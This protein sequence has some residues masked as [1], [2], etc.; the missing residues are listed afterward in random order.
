MRPATRIDAVLFGDAHAATINAACEAK[1]HRFAA[2]VTTAAENYVGASLSIGDDGAPVLRPG[3]AA[4]DIRSH[5]VAKRAAK[6]SAGLNRAFAMGLPMYTTLGLSGHL[7]MRCLTEADHTSPARITAQAGAHFA[8][9]LAMY[10]LLAQRVCL[11]TAIFAPTRFDT[12]TRDAWMIFD[13]VA[14]AQLA[15]AGV[16]ILDL[17]DMLNDQTGCLR[18]EFAAPDPKDRVHAG[19]AWGGVV[20][21]AILAR[22]QPPQT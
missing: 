17:R 14:A 11:V 9:Y 5:K 3:S 18:P 19:I 10:R 2:T 12:T 8:P 7:F 22:H 13:D 21:D 1:G 15:Q 6:V 20:F 4:S 16:R